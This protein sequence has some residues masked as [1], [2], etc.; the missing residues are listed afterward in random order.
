MHQRIALAVLL[1]AAP[2]AALG[3]FFA[4]TGRVVAAALCAAYLCIVTGGIW[5]LT[6]AAARFKERLPSDRV[7]TSDNAPGVS[8]PFTTSEKV[9]YGATAV[10]YSA[11]FIA[12]GV[13]G[14]W[15]WAGIVCAVTLASIGVH[16]GQV[17]RGR[18]FDV[19]ATIDTLF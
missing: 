2:I 17:K 16:T 13:T 3:V 19:R 18:P 15:Y 9:G 14:D 12:T 8:K 11:A 4:L 10:A 6:R 5:L 7:S 1:V